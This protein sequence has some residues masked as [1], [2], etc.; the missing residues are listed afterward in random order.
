[1]TIEHSLLSGA[2]LHNSKVLTF[3]G[4]PAA[5]VPTEAGILVCC[6]TAP[7]V[8]KLYRTTGIT[9]GDV[10]LLATGQDGA[11]ATLSIGSVGT[12]SPSDPPTVANSG[13][14]NNA[15]LD[16]T[17]PAN[18]AVAATFNGLP[19]AYVPAETGVLV[20][21]S[22]V[23]P[24]QLY[25][26][27]GT[28]TGAVVAVGLG[29][30]DLGELDPDLAALAALTTTG[31]IERTGAGTASTFTVTAFAKTLLDDADATTA[32]G[33]LGLGTLATQ[34]SN[35]VA[36][37][38]GSISGITDLAIADGGTG[39]STAA[40]AR[41]NLGA[42]TIGSSLFTLPNPGAIRFP[43]INADNTASS[44]SAT[45]LRD[46]IAAQPLDSDL[47]TLAGLAATA[48]N[49]I[50]GNGMFWT[51]QSGATARSSLELGSAA[52]ANITEAA[53]TPTIIGTTTAGTATYSNQEGTVWRLGNLIIASAIL[54]WTGHTGTGD[55]RVSLPVAVGG[56]ER[57][58][59]AMFSSFAALSSMP[60]SHYLSGLPLHD[61]SQVYLIRTPLGA[62]NPL[63][64]PV[65]G[66]GGFGMVAIYWV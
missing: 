42:T 33:T 23:T 58:G 37:T 1:M 65:S 64:M 36:I 60:A 46:A 29:E 4:D 16:F 39:A 40:A 19:T 50:V 61:T 9:A 8:G 38:G 12:T 35:N 53:W 25:R 66:S 49:F 17:F 13:T 24:N 56:I 11:A 27:T 48:G 47:T 31:A 18:L 57:R 21:R 55:M 10:T 44:L 22:D 62:G 32:R 5:Y 45:E 41:T 14:A 59:C 7:N 15:V 30:L 34:A 43:R 26:T 51:V 52:L 54:F 2:A 6:L 3:T 28:T 20:V 63:P